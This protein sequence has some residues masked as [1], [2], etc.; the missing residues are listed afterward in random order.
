MR[1]YHHGRFRQQASF[2]RRQF[3]QNGDLPFT[4]ILSDRV[5]AFRWHALQFSFRSHAG[6]CLIWRSAVTPARVTAN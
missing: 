3:L 1:S 4:D 2:L 5:L 6:P